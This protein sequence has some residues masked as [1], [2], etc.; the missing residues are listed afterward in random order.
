MPI[1]CIVEISRGPHWR[2]SYVTCGP[3]RG[4]DADL[5]IYLV[6]GEARQLAE[7][8]GRE[9]SVDLS[10]D[11]CGVGAC[12]PSEGPDASPAGAIDVNGDPVALDSLCEQ[13]KAT[14]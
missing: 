2:T 7:I 10:E 3:P 8:F 12:W 5:S 4:S 13:S 6:A 14:S 11:Y 9:T 1:D